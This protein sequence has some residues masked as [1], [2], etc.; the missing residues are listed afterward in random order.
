MKEKAK[1]TREVAKLIEP[2]YEEDEMGRRYL[3]SIDFHDEILW[4][5]LEDAEQV[6]AELKQKLQRWYED[7]GRWIFSQRESWTHPELPED[8]K[9]RFIELLKEEKEAQP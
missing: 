1:T 5:R 9:E 8:L 7:L 6:L 3:S 2:N 4:V